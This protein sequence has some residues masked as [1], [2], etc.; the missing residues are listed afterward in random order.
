MV[1][2]P[3]QPTQHHA[4][5]HLCIFMIGINTIQKKRLKF[6]WFNSLSWFSFEYQKGIGILPDDM[7]V[8]VNISLLVSFIDFPICTVI[9]LMLLLW[10]VTWI[11]VWSILMTNSWCWEDLVSS[12]ELSPSN[13]WCHHS[14]LETFDF[15]VKPFDTSTFCF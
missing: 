15:H 10:T 1:W 5:V 9:I 7:M 2:L 8:M 12:A 3:L 11:I 4:L 6:M 14:F 13:V